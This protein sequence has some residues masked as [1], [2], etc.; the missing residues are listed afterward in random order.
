[1]PDNLAPASEPVRPS[2]SFESVTFS[3]GQ[4]LSFDEDEIIVFVGPNNAGKSASLRQLQNWVTRS[5]PQTVIVGATFRKFG[6]SSDLRQYLEKKSQKIGDTVNLTYSGIG[7]GIHNTH[8]YFF[9]QPTDRHPVAPFFSAHVATETR[10]TASNPAGAIALHQQAPSHPIHLMLMDEILAQE[11][12][13]LFRTAFGEDLIV[14][15]AGGS[16][17]PLYVGQRPPKAPGEDELAKTFVDRL[18]TTSVPLENQGDGMR[19]FA[20]VLLHVLVSDTH[21]IQFLDEP[22]AFL[23]PPQARLL[24]EYIAQKR[25]AKSQLFIATHSTDILDGLMAGGN[26]KVRIIRIQ[27]Q[28]Q[29]NRVKEL[30][31]EK[32]LAIAKDALTR[33]SGVFKGI[34][35]KHVV[36]TESD[37]DCQFYSSLLNLRSISG[38]IQPDVLFIHAAGKHRMAKL[39]E[40]LKMLDVP[41]SVIADIDILNEEN[42][43]KRLFEIA[44]GLWVDVENHWR[45]IKSGV[46]A[47]K[48]PMNSEQVKRLILKELENVDGVTAFPKT[49]ESAIKRIFQTISAWDSVKHSGRSALRGPC[50]SHFDALAAKCSERGL[51]IVPV[52]ELEGFC[53][54]IE[55]RHGP[56]FVEKVL[57]QR[58]LQSDEEL[59]AARQFVHKI[60]KAA[61]EGPLT[62]SSDIGGEAPN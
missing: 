56:D 18:L 11:I 51:W 47:I 2:I 37:G 13:A 27:R 40:T 38:D 26:S 7:Y 5:I 62:P 22:E 55:A 23:H 57:E 49:T 58:D 30:S 9:D 3:D 21:S 42:T 41:V 8:L 53:R 12:S 43:F 17:F 36:I 14:F 25:R 19:S 48:P 15:R 46:E 34:F 28:G 29:I 50:V 4:C 44:G 24:G 1:M 35:Y 20:T 16:S 32:A 6:T 60:W 54:S 39:A 61:S 45:A 52:G 31:R 59:Q 33:Y 10:I